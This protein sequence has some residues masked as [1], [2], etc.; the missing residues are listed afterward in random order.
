[1][2]E[3]VV[4]ALATG[5]GAAEQI[6]LEAE[7]SRAVVEGIGMPSVEVPGAPAVITDRARELAA[8]A[9]PRAWG[10]EEEVVVAVEGAGEGKR[11][12]GS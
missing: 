4:Q 2:T 7:T 9:V 5:R 12:L 1:M 11:R 10:L 6:E 8:V 3:V